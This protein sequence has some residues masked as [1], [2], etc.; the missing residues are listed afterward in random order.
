MFKFSYVMG[1]AL[2]GELPCQMIGLVLSLLSGSQL[3]KETKGSRFFS[4]Q[5]DTI[6]EVS[7][8]REANRKLTLKVTITTAADGIHKYFFIVFRRK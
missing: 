6:L 8:S 3:L 2:I 5:I 7:L 4:L 1:K